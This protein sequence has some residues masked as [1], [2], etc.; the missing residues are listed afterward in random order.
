MSQPPT[1]LRR[2][3]DAVLK[4]FIPFESMPPLGCHT[5]RA[6]DL[7][8]MTLFV[9]STELLGGARDGSRMPAVFAVDVMKVAAVFEDVE[10]ISW[11]P[12]RIDDLDEIGAHLAIV[13]TYEGCRVWLRIL[14]V[15]PEQFDPGRFADLNEMRFVDVW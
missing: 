14:A 12:H 4:G 9:S 1:C 6:E 5:F 11:Q 10:E 15:A 8:E 2:L 3:A 13:G 7:W